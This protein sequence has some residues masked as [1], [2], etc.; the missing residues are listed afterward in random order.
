MDQATQVQRLRTVPLASSG[1]AEPSSAK[2]AGGIG[3]RQLTA[4][5]S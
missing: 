2:L 3:V 1:A 4:S 5:Q